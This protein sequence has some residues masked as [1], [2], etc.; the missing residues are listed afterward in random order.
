MR[1]FYLPIILFLIIAFTGCSKKSD[2]YYMG[3]AKKSVGEKN[4]PAAVEAYQNLVT[5]YPNSPMA[6]QALFELASLYQ[7]K[8]VKSDNQANGQTGLNDTQS[9]EKAISLFKSIFDKYPQSDY[10]PKA[11]FMAGFI[12]SNDLKEFNDATATFNL[13]IQKYPNN[14]MVSSAK[15]ELNNMGLTPEDILKKK[16]DS[17][18]NVSKK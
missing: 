17:K 6:P 18:V 15:E 1:K 7:N 9:L 8:M 14:E 13:F 10:A 2:D 4:I 12:Q 11:L 3:Q 5:N 16:N